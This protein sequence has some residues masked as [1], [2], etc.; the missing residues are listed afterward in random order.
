MMRRQRSEGG[1][2]EPDDRLDEG[3]EKVRVHRYW[4]YSYHVPDTFQCWETMVSQT[5]KGLLFQ[6]APNI[7]DSDMQTIA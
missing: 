4:F 7:W 5:D 2:T 6:Y 1:R 3:S